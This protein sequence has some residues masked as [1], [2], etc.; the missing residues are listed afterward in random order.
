MKTSNIP[1]L[2]DLDIYDE[3]AFER[4]F[5]T[6]FKALHSYA[7]VMLRDEEQAEEVVQQV[8]LKLWERREQLSVQVSIKAYLYKSVHNECLNYFQRNKTKTRF[9]DHAVYVST[10]DSQSETASDKVELKELQAKIHESLND[11]P[12]QCRIIFH[13]SRFEDMKYREIADR[14]GLSVKTVENQMGKALKIMRSKLSDFL[15][16][17]LLGV[18]YRIFS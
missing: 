16:L 2:P 4:M 6:H 7:H 18:L 1:Q 11:L 17:V 8:F 5:K 13:M 10:L 3:G 9:E 15:P 14:L 12:Q